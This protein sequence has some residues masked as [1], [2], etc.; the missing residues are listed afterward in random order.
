MPIIFVFSLCSYTLKGLTGGCLVENEN[1]DGQI[2]KEN[3]DEKPEKRNRIG[4]GL[5]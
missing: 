3:I 1:Q 2:G 5:G 4:N